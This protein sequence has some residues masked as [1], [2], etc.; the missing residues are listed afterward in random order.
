MYKGHYTKPYACFSFSLNN[1][2]C[3]SWGYDSTRRSSPL[4]YPL[5]TFSSPKTQVLLQQQFQ[6]TNSFSLNL[7]NPRNWIPFLCHAVPRVLPLPS[8]DL[9][10]GWPENLIARDSKNSQFFQGFSQQP[11]QGSWTISS[12]W[13]IKYMH[14]TLLL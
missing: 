5:S 13:N 6:C 14:K 11:F 3:P 2:P 1:N 9:V 4:G 10:Y 12:T 7:H 8:R